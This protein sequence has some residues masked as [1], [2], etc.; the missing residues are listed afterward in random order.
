MHQSSFNLSEIGTTEIL[1]MSDAD[2]SYVPAFLQQ[3][4]ADVHFNDL[5]HNLAWRQD[6]IKLYGREVLIPRLQA[7]YGEPE[8]EYQYSGLLM[9]PLSWT[10]SLRSL[11][12][13]CEEHCQSSFNSVLANLYRD[14]RDSMGMH[15]DDEPELGPQPV[16]ASLSLGE[17]RDFRFKHKRTGERVQVCLAHGSLLVMKGQTQAN[18]QH[19]MNKTKRSIGERINLT[20]RY[21][22]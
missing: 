14:G 18:W 21:I 17:E 1:E 9:R 8:A 5:L 12:Q 2:V 10:D 4:D 6:H 19:G 7:W 20:F 16:I 13:Q 22:L 15:S 11:K 3:A